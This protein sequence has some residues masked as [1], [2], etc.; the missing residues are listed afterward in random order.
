MS[1]FLC[2]TSSDAVDTIHNIGIGKLLTYLYTPYIFALV[3]VKIPMTQCVTIMGKTVAECHVPCT[4]MS[5]S[6]DFEKE[7]AHCS[8]YQ[9]LNCSSLPNSPYVFIG[10]L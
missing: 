10:S 2:L 5:S 3:L 6:V 9:R 1:S 8:H 4:L 7:H